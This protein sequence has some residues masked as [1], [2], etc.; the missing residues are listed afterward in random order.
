MKAKQKEALQAYV[1]LLPAL[2]TI[3]TFVI[4][5]LIYSAVV[6][7]F[8]WSFYTESTFVGLKNYA[9]VLSDNKFWDAMLVSLKFV[10]ILL[11]SQ[12]VLAFIFG[13]LLRRLQGKTASFV[14]TSIY[15]PYVMSGIVTGLLFS[16]MYYYEGGL[17]NSIAGWFGIEKIAWLI[18]PKFVDF[19]VV[20]PA[21]WISLGYNSLLI[22]AGLNDIPRIYYEAA[23]LEGASPWRQTIFITVPLMRNLFVFII[24]TGVIGTLQ[25][26][27]LPL[28]LTNGGP[29]DKTTT[30]MLLIYRRYLIDSDL[31]F[32]IA[33]SLV[34]FVILGT[35]S[36]FI[37]KLINSQK[38]QE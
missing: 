13:L 34:M 35:V 14:K 2:I 31:D 10:A 28:I 37:F 22:L 8:N 16:F 11:P 26:F 12:V 1:F 21:I 33:A 32:S 18:D 9:R 17:L 20:L 19:A 4:L 25:F 30:P 15:I 7:F 6:S 38:A 36:A 27:D 24:V 29:M 23:S 3:T 5:P